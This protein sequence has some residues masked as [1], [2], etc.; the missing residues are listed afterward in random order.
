ME[1]QVKVITFCDF[2]QPNRADILSNHYTF[3][4][5]LSGYKHAWDIYHR[6][7]GWK[8]WQEIPINIF[9]QRLIQNN[10]L[11][12][13]KEHSIEI[14]CRSV[15]LQGLIFLPIEKLPENLIEARSYI[16]ELHQSAVDKNVS[17]SELALAFVG[18]IDEIDK[19]VLGM[20]SCQQ[21]EENFMTLKDLDVKLDNFIQFDFK[22][23]S[24]N[25]E[26]I[27]NPSLWNK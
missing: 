13:I 24:I 27:I 21:L 3:K 22:R 14:H 25:N 23:F 9:D 20:E 7:H 26:Y 19:L 18:L 8:V 12:L 1:Q 6:I 11:H 5:A 17:I 15:F 10:Y 2:G 4:G 16:E